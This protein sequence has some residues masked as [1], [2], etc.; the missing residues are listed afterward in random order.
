MKFIRLATVVALSTTILAGGA[1]AA[2]AEEARKVTT[3][4]EVQFRAFDPEEDGEGE[5]NEVIP[6]VVDPD[7]I[8]EPTEPGSTGP[9]TIAYAPTLNFGKQVISNQDREYSMV[10]EMQALANPDE[11]DDSPTEVPY[12]SF[13][14]VQDTRG[15][16]TGW[17]LKVS[18]SQFTADTQNDTLTGAQ[19]TFLDPQIEYPGNTPTNAPEAHSNR[20]ELKPG[21]GSVTLMEAA[22]TKG[23]GTSSVVWGDQ[24]D[25]NDQ[26]EDEEVDVVKNEAIV[27]SIPGSTAKDAATYTSTLTWELT[28]TPDNEDT[29]EEDA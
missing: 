26:F 14:Q 3:E 9:L 17:D 29:D 18:L 4:G 6:P 21:T 24:A 16:N 22:A 15:T 13:A 27:L 12:V 19:I 10:A 5:E 20:L 2:F 23:A 1:T 7:V 8:I 25:L 11:E 28:A